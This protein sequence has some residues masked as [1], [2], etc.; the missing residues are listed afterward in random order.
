[1][2]LAALAPLAAVVIALAPSRPVFAHALLVASDPA[3]GAVLQSAPSEVS[4]RFSEPV[5]AAGA[6]LSVLAPS[7]RPAGRGA[8]RATGTRLSV[9]LAASEEGTYLVR[10]EVIAQDTHPSRGELTFSIGRVGPAP[11]SDELRADIGAVSPVGLGLQASARWLHFLGLALGFGVVAFQVLAWPAPSRR[12]DRLVMAGVVLL[13]L[14]EPMALAGQSAS[15]GL[16]PQDLVASS[17]GRAAALRLGGALLL[18][19]AAGAVR[20]AGRGRPGLLALGGAVTLA[21][22]LAGHRIAG[23]PDLGAF[24]LGAVH[25]AAMAVWM[26]GLAA[27]LAVREGTERF[28]WIAAGAL[29]M[30]VVSGALLA[31]AHLRSFADLAATP[32]GAVLAVKVA[33]LGGVLV[34]AW[35]RARRGEGAALAGVLALAGLLVSLPP[36]R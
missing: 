23:L 27:L 5:T 20:M 28:R 12:L 30:L 18:W 10:W 15:L 13:A 21:D 24:A 4:L 11:T 9:A 1:M 35:M 26:G 31:A 16:P 3:P 19:A 14:A 6:G 8:A 32:Y 33:A 36:P 17:F 7:H 25:E 22:G 2:L 29:A 34:F